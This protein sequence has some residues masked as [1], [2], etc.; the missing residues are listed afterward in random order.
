MPQMADEMVAFP[1]IESSPLQTFLS[2]CADGKLLYQVTEDGTPVFFP[3]LFA[4][5]TGGALEWRESIGTGVVHAATTAYPRGKEPYNVVLVD[6]DEGF[7]LMSTVR[8]FGEHEIPIGLRVQVQMEE[9]E[10]EPRPVFV[11]AN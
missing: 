8:G 6:M 3:R 2:G 4:P 9:I 7:R 5:R 11:A 1:P 10:G